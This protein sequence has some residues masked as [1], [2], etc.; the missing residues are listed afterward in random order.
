MCG[1]AAESPAAAA[2]SGVRNPLSKSASLGERL[3]E[4]A[5]VSRGERLLELL[6][7]PLGERL[8]S[9]LLLPAAERRESLTVLPAV[10]ALWR[11]CETDDLP[12]AG[13]RP[14]NSAPAPNSAPPPAPCSKAGRI[15]T[16]GGRSEDPGLSAS[17]L[18]E[19]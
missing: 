19:S 14:P 4:L 11:Y 7:E 8:L 5:S 17:L 9:P 18:T 15:L 3:L 6:G 13:R 10:L 16:L 12:F 2:E 1:A